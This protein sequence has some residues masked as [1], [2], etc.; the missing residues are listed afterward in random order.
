MR[1][2]CQ[3][4]KEEMHEKDKLVTCD[5]CHTT[6][7]ANENCTKLGPSEYRAVILQ[8]RSLNFFCYECRGTFKKIPLLLRQIEDFRN[9]VNIMKQE[10]TELKNKNVLMEAEL[11][12]LKNGDEKM[13]MEEFINEM[14]ERRKRANNV[15]IINVNESNAENRIHRLEDEKNTVK[16]LLQNIDSNI[17]NFRV[18]RG[19]KY[20]GRKS[21][22]IKVILDS[23][24]SVT[25][26]Q[27]KSRIYLIHTA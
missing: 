14:E 26:I 19:G 17:E 24:E 22:P 9:E 11:L 16:Q 5:S 27:T 25:F 8:N 23:N 20:D 21:R 3:T 6:M 10:I 1:R 12:K 18:M 2:N 7:H 4:C 13:E 15:M